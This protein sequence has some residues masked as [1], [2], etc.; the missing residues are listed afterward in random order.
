I[1]LKMLLK[2][3]VVAKL[4]EWLGVYKMSQEA[5]D[6]VFN[7]PIVK[8]IMGTILQLID[9]AMVHGNKSWVGVGGSTI[10]GTIQAAL[11][12]QKQRFGGRVLAHAKKEMSKP[13]TPNETIQ[14]QVLGL[15]GGMLEGFKV[16]IS[17][18]IDDSGVKADFEQVLDEL[19]EGFQKSSSLG[20]AFKVFTGGGGAKSDPMRFIVDL[21]AKKLG[22]VVLGIMSAFVQMPAWAKEVVSTVSE[23]LRDLRAMM[24]RHDKGNAARQLV[25]IGGKVLKRVADALLD[26]AAI[27]D[28]ALTE[29]VKKI[30][31]GGSWALENT[32]EVLALFEGKRSPW[33]AVEAIADL[34]RDYAVK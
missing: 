29:L 9:A 25:G 24:D 16:A 32:D 28:E 15:V 8:I 22:P 26:R 10:P 14:Q 11:Q 20:E 13:A 21:L 23:V 4:P 7:N 3:F 34:V 18:R 2:Q 27:G 17:R 31:A 12:D 1:G 6:K 30:F 33:T 5:I 19:K